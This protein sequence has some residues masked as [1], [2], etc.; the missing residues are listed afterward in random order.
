MRPLLLCLLAVG[1]ASFPAAKSTVGGT[2]LEIANV[3]EGENCYP[4]R[5]VDHDRGVLC[6]YRLRTT[7]DDMVGKMLDRHLPGNQYKARLELE[8]VKLAT[9]PSNPG[10]LEK[11]SVSYH[12][13]LTAADGK[14]VLDLRNAIDEDV[15]QLHHGTSRPLPTEMVQAPELYRPPVLYQMFFDMLDQISQGID[16]A[17]L[18]V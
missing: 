13:T 8:S 18:N 12:F 14:P 16:A 9:A 5:G 6:A 17:R 10:R 11:R 15:P 3:P 1:C 7:L 2:I 4:I